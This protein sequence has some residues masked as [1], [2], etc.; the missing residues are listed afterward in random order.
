[1]TISSGPED[2]ST[3]SD[4]NPSFSFASDDPDASFRCQL[5]SG[6]FAPCSSP[7]SA[8]QLANG[9]HSFQVRATDEAGNIG[10]ATVTWKIG[11]AI[12][13]GPT[14]GSPTNDPTPRFVFA[15]PDAGGFSCR[16]DGVVVVADCTSPFTSQALSDGRHTFAVQHGTDTASRAFA[17]DTTLPVVSMVKG[18]AD[19]SVTKD[20]TPRFRFSSTEPRT[21]FQCRYEGHGF[22]ACSGARSDTAAR[23][24]SEGSHT[25]FVRAADAAG[26]E[27]DVVSRSFTVDTVPPTVTIKGTRTTASKADRRTRAIFILQASED[28]SLRCRVDSRPYKACASPYRT[29]KLTPGA[30][31]LKVKATDEAGNVGTKRKKFKIA[32]RQPRAVSSPAANVPSHPRC[33]G[34]AATLIGTPHGDKLRGTNGPD[35]IVGFA[36]NDVIHG[37]GGPDLICG[38]RGDDVVRGGSGDDRVLGGPGSDRIRAGSG[39]DTVR[40]GSS[41][42]VCGGATPASRTFHCERALR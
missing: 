30:H 42:D 36:G 19:G 9:Q 7:Y 8:S 4:P 25:F 28:V 15:A 10:S 33:H 12:T 41:V 21:T 37:R 38:R 6:G 17:I 24:L 32:K 23:D 29:P 27:S 2:G 40:G 20:P 11:L 1:M 35:V 5:D 18:P 16:I 39:R 3:S 13:S 14:S 22:S 26:N 34:F 31:R